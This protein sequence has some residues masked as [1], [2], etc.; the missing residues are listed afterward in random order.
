MGDWSGGCREIR[1][2]NVSK[3]QG[4]VWLTLCRVKMQEEVEDY[5]DVGHSRLFIVEG[6]ELSITCCPLTFTCLVTCMCAK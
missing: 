5:F 4:R 3:M 6:E 1:V 2:A